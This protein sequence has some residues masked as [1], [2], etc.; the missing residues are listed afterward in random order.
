MS[1]DT[2]KPL[3]AVEIEQKLKQERQLQIDQSS[4][5][6]ES[7]P[8]PKKVSLGIDKLK[9]S[10]KGTVLLILFFVLSIGALSLYYFPSLLRAFISSDEAEEVPQ[11]TISTGGRDKLTG[12]NNDV[13]PFGQAELY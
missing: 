1:E 8:E 12:L 4:E 6:K 9:K 11:E 3:T 5:N 7:T 10:K 2:E 13:D